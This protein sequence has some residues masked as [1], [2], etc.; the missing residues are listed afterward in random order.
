VGQLVQQ[1]AKEISCCS[2]CNPDAVFTLSVVRFFSQKIEQPPPRF[3]MRID[4]NLSNFL[5]GG[6]LTIPLSINELSRKGTNDVTQVLT[7][8]RL[9]PTVIVYARNYLAMLLVLNGVVLVIDPS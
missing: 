4:T 6:A 7:V 8:V 3:M 5:Q 1:G 2:H 9:L